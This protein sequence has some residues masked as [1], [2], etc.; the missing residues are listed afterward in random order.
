M[1]CE[2]CKRRFRENELIYVYFPDYYGVR[3]NWLGFC[4]CHKPFR[5]NPDKDKLKIGKVKLADY[6]GEYPWIIIENQ[7]EVLW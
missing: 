7:E 6:S 3:D 2:V 1:S 4:W 5:I